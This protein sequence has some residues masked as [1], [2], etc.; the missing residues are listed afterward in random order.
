MM[1]ASSKSGS[2]PAAP[3]A[4]PGRRRLSGQR[5][6]RDMDVV[7]RTLDGRR[8]PRHCRRAGITLLFNDPATDHATLMTQYGQASTGAHI[9]C[10]IRARCVRSRDRA[11]PPL[12]TT[13]WSWT[14]SGWHQVS[15]V[16]G[17]QQIPEFAGASVAAVA[18]HIV[19]LTTTGETWT[20]AAGQWTQDIVANG[21]SIRSGA[22][23]AA[24]PSGT[25]VL[26]GGAGKF[27]G[28][29]VA[30]SGRRPARSARTPGCGTRPLGNMPGAPR[31][32]RHPHPAPV[33]T[34]SA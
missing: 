16:P 14:A 4:C 13:T 25:V 3:I 8:R 7:R 27:P 26:F 6:H 34:S 20:F 10:Q 29:A 22:A 19:V 32:R 31:R 23:M 12:V 33:R 9:P 21:P 5:R 11:V 30:S 2:S 15:Q 17:L 1:G 18:G 28:F 24:G